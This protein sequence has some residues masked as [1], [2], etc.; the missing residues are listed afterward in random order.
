MNDAAVPS[1]LRRI[2]RRLILRHLIQVPQADRGELAAVANTSQVTAG[3]IVD[4][5]LGQG[6]LEPAEARRDASRPGRPGQALRLDSKT[7]RFILIQLGVRQT[8]VAFVPLLLG[9]E[10]WPIEFITPDSAKA[11]E[12]KLSSVIASLQFEGPRSCWGVLVS[13]PGM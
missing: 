11:W 12:E 6:V 4:E 9:E 3:R 13:V 2:N 1:T 7:P 10:S 5:L 8:R